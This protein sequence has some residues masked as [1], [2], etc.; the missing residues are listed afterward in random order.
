MA[1]RG[2]IAKEEVLNKILETFPGAFK[3]DKE[4]RVPII[5][6]GEQVQIKVTLTC[7]KVN[8]ENG[9]DNAIPGEI[10]TPVESRGLRSKTSVIDEAIAPTEEEKKNVATLL[11]SLGLV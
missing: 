10:A 11:E 2:A 4:I 5:E 1:A 3:Y 8:V 9:A 6:N 7:A